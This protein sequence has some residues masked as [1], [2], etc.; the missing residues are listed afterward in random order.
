MKLVVLGANGRTGT[1]VTRAALEQGFC[2]T[3]VVRALGR[4]PAIRHDRL[5]VVVG[6]PCDAA[7]LKPVFRGQDVVIS[8]LGGR[9]PTKSA[10]SVYARSAQA[11]VDAAWDTGLKRVLV[12]STALLFPADRLMDRLL[13]AL[14]PNVVRNAARMEA[15]L[16][17]SALDWTSARCGFLTNGDDAAYRTAKDALPEKGAAISRSALARFLVDAIEAPEARR[18]VFGVA[19]AQS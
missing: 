1:R 14:V 16:A 13:Q 4:R 5:T 17:A 11:I 8:T 12:T 2:V 7:F 18:A 6:D 19:G 9:R 3:A 10:T 15:I